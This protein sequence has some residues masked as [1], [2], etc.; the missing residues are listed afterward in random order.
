MSDIENKE[1]NSKKPLIQLKGYKYRTKMLAAGAAILLVIIILITSMISSIASAIQ[2][3]KDKTSTE[4]TISTDVETQSTGSDVSSGATVSTTAFFDKDKVNF[5]A[6]G[7]LVIGTDTLDG[8]K[9]VA[10]TFDDGPGNFTEKLISGL[11]E[12]G[13]KATFYMLGNCVSEYPEVLPMMVEGGHQLGNHTYDHQ[14][15]T[16]ISAKKVEEQIT[17][18][19]NAIFDACGQRSTAFRPPYGNYTDDIAKT[20]DK[21]FSMWSLDTIDWQLRDADAIKKYIVSNCKDGDIILL[22]DIYEE[23]VDGALS[24]VDELQKKGYVFVTMDE[25]LGRYGY[26][27]QKG[28]AYSTQY[29]VYE[30]N[31]PYAKK[32]EEE[33]EASKAALDASSAATAFHDSSDS[34]TNS[35]S[36]TS[37]NDEQ[38]EYYDDYYYWDEE[39]YYDY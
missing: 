21:T 39:D 7:K 19:D 23:S 36:D 24:A 33:I 14:D 3:G 4:S 29:A 16:A 25:L 30:T 26:T 10:L 31:S 11:N 38:D 20:V 8:K 2:K 34:D 35:S 37:S 12:R 6:D 18:T 22:H 1:N 27:V 28:V 9:A 15:I 5:D 13:A 32:Y 17:T